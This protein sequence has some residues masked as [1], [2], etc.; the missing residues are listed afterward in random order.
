MATRVCGRGLHAVCIIDGARLGSS[1]R[2]GANASR[3]GARVVEGAVRAEDAMG[4]GEDF[5]PMPFLAIQVV[6]A[7][8]DLR[9]CSTIPTFDTFD[10]L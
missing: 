1:I 4:K 8:I 5:F 10:A 7:G 2:K 3:V 9:F 6:G